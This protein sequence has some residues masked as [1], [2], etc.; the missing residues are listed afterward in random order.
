MPTLYACITSTVPPSSN[1]S[2]ISECCGIKLNE[3]RKFML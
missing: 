3:A 1:L 2:I